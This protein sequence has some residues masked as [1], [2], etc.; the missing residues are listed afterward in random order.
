[1][2]VRAFR[3]RSALQRASREPGAVHMVPDKPHGTVGDDAVVVLVRLDHHP[4]MAGVTRSRKIVLGL[5]HTLDFDAR[6]RWPLG[7]GWPHAPTGGP[8]LLP[9]AV[10]ISELQR[11]THAASICAIVGIVVPSWRAVI[12]CRPLVHPAAPR[13][14]R[15]E[16]SAR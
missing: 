14:P 16:C 6:A 12:R 10:F 3:P 1:R 4:R 11:A 5:H 9:L 15:A 2:A 13:L 8:E 7:A